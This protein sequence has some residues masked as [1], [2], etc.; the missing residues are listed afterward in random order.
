VQFF[1]RD[2]STASQVWSG[3]RGY[4]G[5]PAYLEFHKKSDGGG[6]R[7][8]KVSGSGVDLGDKE[9]Y[10]PDD[11]VDRVADHA[12][13]FC[14]VVCDRLAGS[15]EGSIL[16]A[17]YDAEL[18]GH[19]WH[20]GVSWLEAVLEG[21]HAEPHLGLTTL[22]DHAR[23]FPPTEVVAL[24][25]GSW[26]EG[27]HDYVWNNPAVA[28]TW[29]L[30]YASEEAVWDLWRAA[31]DSD[32]AEARLIA[33]AAVRQLLLACASDWPFLITTGSAVD[34][35]TERV[36]LHADDLARLA[37][38]GRRVLDGH[39]PDPV[40]AQFVRTIEERDRLFPELGDVLLSLAAP[41]TAPSER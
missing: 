5:D 11:A 18:F 30:I 32:R 40:E 41:E 39:R 9:E 33:V 21:L 13:H 28:W 31:R 6:H 1:T 22:G 14:R 3:E 29:Q 19:W 38:L 17:P 37:D 34:Y 24:P 27:G 25:E 7:Y 8:W 2:P 35:A 23:E 10:V 16:V 26:G 4:P 20:E 15:A 36:R 12:D